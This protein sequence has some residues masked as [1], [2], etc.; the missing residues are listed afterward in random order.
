MISRRA[1]AGLLAGAALLIAIPAL[2]QESPESLLPPGFGDPQ[3]LPPPAERTP[4]QPQ[5]PRP[6]APRPDAAAQPAEQE[7]GGISPEEA[8]LERPR[9]TNYF[10]IPDG[11][12]RPTDLVGPLP[13]GRYGLGPDAFGPDQGALSAEIMRRLDAPLPS[14]WTSILLRRALMSRLQAPAGINPVDWVAERADLLLR[15]GEADAARMLVQAVDQQN[16]TPRLI[17]V[18]AR[19]ALATADPAALCPLVGTTR[20]ANRGAVWSLAEAMCAALESEPARAAALA[21]QARAQGGIDLALAEKVIGAG[22]SSRR[23]AAVSWD[24]VNE[25][26]PWRFGLASATGT[27]I[28]APLIGNAGLPMRAWFARAPMVPLEQRLEAASIAAA[29]GIF[30]SSALVQLH[31][32]AFDLTDVAE[33]GGTVA[34]RLRIAWAGAGPTERLTALRGLWTEPADPR[35]RYARLILTSGAAA[36]IP[37]SADHASDA[38]N[39][40][41]AM[42]AAGMDAEAA[43]WADTAQGDDRAWALLAV[44]APGAAV[45]LGAGRIETYIGNDDSADGIRARM[46]VAALVGLGKVGDADGQRLASAAGLSIGAADRWANAIDQAARQRQPGTV[47]LLAGLG[48]QTDHWGSVPP[49]HLFR[50]VR[51]LRAVGLDFEARMIAAEAIARL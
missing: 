42:L 30:S 31:S 8:L 27:E 6:D 22:A 23:A 50:I 24:G 10:A 5:A 47:V 43:R 11:E 26:T 3:A 38:A 33:Q 17:E 25:L 35:G 19:T 2:S 1:K 51:A 28:P 49:R 13:G 34:A 16:Y 36:R 45:D 21:D 40:I 32:L 14:R 9:P 48:M 44:G 15:M 4:A 46:L 18:A 29:L 37:V 12:A 7:S 41:A 20:G 39:L